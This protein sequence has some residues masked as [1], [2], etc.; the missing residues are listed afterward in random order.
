[1]Q[2]DAAVGDPV[3]QLGVPPL[4]HGGLVVGQPAGAVLGDSAVG[5]LARDRDLGRHLG[6]GEPVVL[7]LAHRLAERAALLA[8]GQRVGQGLFGDG[9]RGD[10]DGDPL[11]RQALHQRDEPAARLAE[12]VGGRHLDVGEE[13]LRGVL[14]VHAELVQVPAAG[15]AGNA[16]LHHEQADPAVVRVRVGACHHDHDV[17]QL[18]VGDERLLA[19]QH[20]AVPVANRRGADALQVTARTGLGHR[21]RRDQLARAVAGEPS[22]P[23]LRRAEPV[24]VRPDHVVVQL[25]HRPAGARAGQFLVQDHVE[26]VVGLT[27]AAVL[28]V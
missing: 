17:G 26:P 14:R 22:V 12:Q 7:E 20:V 25:E 10:A 19:V 24:Q 28:L 3:A 1:M 16:P 4:D 15:E 18:P 6:Q 5:E 27:A 21:D 23:L 8:V 13:Q 2:L 11:P 9:Q